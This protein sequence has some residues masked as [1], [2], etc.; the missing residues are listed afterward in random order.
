MAQQAAIVDKPQPATE[1]LRPESSSTAGAVEPGE[2]LVEEKAPAEDELVDIANILGAP[3]AT[4]IR[5]S[6]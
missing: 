3:A 1:E 6:L 5:S 2:A 4:V